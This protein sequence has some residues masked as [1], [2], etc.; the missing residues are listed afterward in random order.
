MNYAVESTYGFVL[1]ASIEELIPEIQRYLD[2]VETFRAEG[3]EPSW[4]STDAEREA[5]PLG[6]RLALLYRAA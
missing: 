5:R 1:G 3:C 6:C 2:A 4:A